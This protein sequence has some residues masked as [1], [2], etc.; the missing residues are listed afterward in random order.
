MLKLAVEWENI[1]NKTFIPLTQLLYKL[2]AII[3]VQPAKPIFIF[4]IQTLQD[5]A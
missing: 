1:I 3:A 5:A 2:L 4:N